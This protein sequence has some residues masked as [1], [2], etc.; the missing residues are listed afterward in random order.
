MKYVIE[1]DGRLI[2]PF[3]TMEA[4]ATYAISRVF[5]PW[6]LRTLHIVATNPA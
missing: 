5:L 6:T 1:Y 4:A 3:D 2:G